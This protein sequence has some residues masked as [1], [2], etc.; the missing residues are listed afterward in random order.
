PGSACSVPS[1]RW[2]TLNLG[3]GR[4]AGEEEFTSCLSQSFHSLGL[5]S[6]AWFPARRAGPLDLGPAMSTWRNATSR[7][8]TTTAC[9]VCTRARGGL[10]RAR[11]T[12][13]TEDVSGPSWV[14]GA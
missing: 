9:L 3:V 7:S 4:G 8:A 6:I 1:K 13:A 11:R 5:V 14:A 10:P 2:E 12:T